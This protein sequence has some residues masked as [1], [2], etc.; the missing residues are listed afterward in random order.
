MRLR[1][2]RMTNFRQFYG[3]EITLSFPSRPDRNVTVV[4]GANGAGKTTILNAFTWCLY[5]E[6]TPAFSGHEHLVNDRALYEQPIGG[7][8]EANVAVEFEHDGRNYSVVRTRSEKRQEKLRQ[9][10]IVDGERMEVTVARED[11]ST[12]IP[13]N[14][15]EAIEQVLPRRLHS[16]FFFDG[17]RIEHLTRM[18]GG[19]EIERA[20]KSVLGLELLE[21]GTKHLRGKVESEFNAE[22]RKYGSTQVQELAANYESKREQKEELENKRVEVHNN[23]YALEQ[24]CEDIRARLRELEETRELQETIDECEKQELHIQHNIRSIDIDLRERTNRYGYTVFLG[25]V[26]DVCEEI[27]EHTREKGELPA[28]LKVQFV[29]DLLSA[30]KCICGAE[31]RQGTS[32]YAAVE[33][34]R[35][36]A[37]LADVEHAAVRLSAQI[38]NHRDIS[39]RFIDEITNLH[40][41]RAE[42][43][44]R[45]LAVQERI[46]EAKAQLGDR[47]RESEE[48]KGLYQRERDRAEQLQNISRQEGA[49]DADI[50]EAERQLKEL[51]GQY[52][53]AEEKDK[54]AQLAQKRLEVTRETAEFFAALYELRS[55]QVREEIDER[56][57]DVY[58]RI[59]YTGNWPE[60]TSDYRLVVRK[61][62]GEESEDRTVD[63]QKGTGENQLLS[64][65]FIG[66]IAA[67]ARDRHEKPDEEEASFGFAGGLFP[68]V[69]DSPFGV[70]DEN[71]Q[72]PLAEGLPKLANQVVILVSGKQGLGT[73]FKG[74]ENRID[75]SYVLSRSTPKMDAEESITIHG[76]TVSYLQYADKEIVNVIE[77]EP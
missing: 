11:G 41:N 37:G 59:A 73:V 14:P 70:L 7:S 26:T 13:N 74:L 42:E 22:L 4:F 20:V 60:L 44:Q 16:F 43:K 1:K 49:I 53:K 56:V 77:V 75:R 5:G 52:S 25:D 24:E 23:K 46:S 33:Q 31:L 69:I 72:A 9:A 27:L 38:R 8:A 36:R 66:G 64:L 2:L 61:S 6:T 51:E 15:Q 39:E 76:Q 29:E 71:Y 34:W 50:R 58:T 54:R 21:R 62:I 19:E 68:L 12:W 65:A 10:P 48:I 30:G 67:Y 17:E 47:G 35:E 45:L 18:E 55:H 57:R 3:E 28:P 32:A 40:K 63:V